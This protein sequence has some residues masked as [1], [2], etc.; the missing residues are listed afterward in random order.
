MNLQGGRIACQNID[1]L[2]KPITQTLVTP[3][4]HEVV[5]SVPIVKP[6]TIGVP[7]PIVT[8][9]YVP[10]PLRNVRIPRRGLL[11]SPRRRSL[12]PVRSLSPRGVVLK[13]R[14]L[15]PIPVPERLR[16][17]FRRTM[18]KALER[19]LARTVPVQNPHR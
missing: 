10:R 11:L 13:R 5:K 16:P 14:T 1:L 12:S 15:V 7:T 19:E 18:P 17:R 9:M 6:V 3:I 8:P 2:R 4:V